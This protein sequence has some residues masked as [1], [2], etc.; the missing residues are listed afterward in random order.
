MKMQEDKSVQAILVQS[1]NKVN[2]RKKKHEK[3]F[4][5]TQLVL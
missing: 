4:L 5:P 3:L 2:L 1:D